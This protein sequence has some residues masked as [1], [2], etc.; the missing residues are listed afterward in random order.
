MLTNGIVLS[1][2]EFAT[3]GSSGDGYGFGYGSGF[4]DS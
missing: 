2:L 3:V 4:G 1:G